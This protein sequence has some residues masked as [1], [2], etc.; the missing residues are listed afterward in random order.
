M[1]IGPEELD[2]VA[3]YI[4]VVHDDD[5]FGHICDVEDSRAGEFFNTCRAPALE[6]Q[7][8]VREGVHLPGRPSYAN[9]M[10][11]EMH[12]VGHSLRVSFHVS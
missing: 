12:F 10:R 4:D 5:I 1:P 6:A 11:A 8:S 2:G 3:A 9:A 7:V